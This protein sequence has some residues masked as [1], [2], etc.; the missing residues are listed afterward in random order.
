MFRGLRRPHFFLK[1]SPKLYAAHFTMY[2]LCTFCIPLNHVRLPPPVSHTWANVRSHLSLRL[3]FNR[4]PLS[5]LTRLRFARNAFSYSAGLPIPSIVV[6]HMRS[7]NRFRFQVHRVF[8]LVCQVRSSVLH[9]DYSRIRIRRILP[10]P[11]RNLLFL[12]PSIHSPHWLPGSARRVDRRRQGRCV[13]ESQGFPDARPS[14]HSI[15]T[16]GARFANGRRH[17]PGHGA[18]ASKTVSRSPSRGARTNARRSFG[19]G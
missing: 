19:C 10:L 8:R 6:S 12:P 16:S 3:G 14:R 7:H 4:L 18:P 1:S 5:P 13:R 2:D 17:P 11:V 15:R 9:P